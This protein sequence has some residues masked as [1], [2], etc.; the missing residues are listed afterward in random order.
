MTKGVLNIIEDAKIETILQ[1]IPLNLP[2]KEHIETLN[3]F[4]KEDK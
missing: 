3:K 2:K 1:S 4:L